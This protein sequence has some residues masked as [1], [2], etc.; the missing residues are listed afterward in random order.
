MK[1]MFCVQ[2]APNVVSEE[3]RHAA[4]KFFLDFEKS[5][6][7]LEVCRQILGDMQIFI[8]EIYSLMHFNL[9]FFLFHCS[10]Y[11]T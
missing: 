6:I 2:A 1:L 7:S 3:Q 11:R 10:D 4:E 8:K 9:V 5:G